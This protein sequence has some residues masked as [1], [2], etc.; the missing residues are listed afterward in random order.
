MHQHL[1]DLVKLTVTLSRRCVYFHTWIL[2]WNVIW[3]HMGLVTSFILSAWVP[4]LVGAFID[5]QCSMDPLYSCV[6]F[7]YIMSITPEVNDSEEE[8]K[9]EALIP[10]SWGWLVISGGRR[11][12]MG[13]VSRS[14]PYR[15]MLCEEA[16]P[17]RSITHTLLWETEVAQG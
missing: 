5:N 1:F 11:D 16:A 3:K 6:P 8:I 7:N 15:Y 10:V 2:C 17:F 13:T 14:P 4:C 12:S 9:M